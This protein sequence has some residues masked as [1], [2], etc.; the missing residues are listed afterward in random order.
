[1]TDNNE[2]DVPETTAGEDA[3]P[4][5]GGMGPTG[6]VPAVQ[7]SGPA[8]PG[9]GGGQ[10]EMAGLVLLINTVLGG[11]G[12]LYVTT[13]SAEITLCSA[14]LVLVIT[15]VVLVVKRVTG[16]EGG[17]EGEDRGGK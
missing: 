12:T 1:M 16:P 5:P 15:I 6:G 4:A 14:L 9:G 10:N 2:R 11:L 3:A 7:G 17:P 13:K 8:A